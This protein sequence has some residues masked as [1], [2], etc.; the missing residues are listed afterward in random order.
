M[1]ILLSV[2]RQQPYMVDTLLSEGYLNGIQFYTRGCA[3][4]GQDFASLGDQVQTLAL[5]PRLLPFFQNSYIRQIT[6][7]QWDS[8]LEGAISLE[9]SEIS[10]WH[11][12]EGATFVPSSSRPDIGLLLPFDTTTDT[13]LSAFTVVGNRR[14]FLNLS[15]TSGWQVTRTVV[16]SNHCSPPDPDIGGCGIGTC[17][18]CKKIDLQIDDLPVVVCRCPCP[19]A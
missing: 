6:V 10:P 1:N 13:H 11:P 5:N 15:V 19:P 4:L 2:L 7:G 14:R 17:Q 12:I 9:P 8:L 18:K 3:A 16:S